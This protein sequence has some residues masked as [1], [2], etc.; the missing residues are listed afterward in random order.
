[1]RLGRVHWIAAGV[2]AALLHAAVFAGL[3]TRVPGEPPGGPAPQVQVLG[4]AAQVFGTDERTP[5]T[6]SPEPSANAPEEIATGAEHNTTEEAVPQAAPVDAK[7]VKAT[8]APRPEAITPEAVET[9]SAHRAAE[10]AIPAA[11]EIEA[12]AAHIAVPAR[13]PKPSEAERRPVSRPRHSARKRARQR[14]QPRRQTSSTHQGQRRSGAR[15]ASE[16]RGAGRQRAAASPGEVR[17]YAAAVRARIARNRP[18]SQGRRGTALV[19]FAISRSG[20]LRYA[21][22]ARSSGDGALDRAAVGSVRRAA[23]FPTPPQGMR[24]DQLT[25]SIPFRFR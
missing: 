12:D 3:R 8:D 17:S 1:M 7:P 13:R 19:R 14:G 18:P 2:L 24:A 9:G 21:R 15:A 5:E 22:L 23:P 16:R 20:S 6:P 4:S 10:A 11:G 25:F